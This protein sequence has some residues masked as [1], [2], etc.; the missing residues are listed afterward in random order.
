MRIEQRLTKGQLAELEARIIN[1]LYTLCSGG[2][3]FGIDVPTMRVLFPRQMSVF[4]RL[5]KQY[6]TILRG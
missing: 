6:Q 3:Q 5:R 1:R 4:T 2:T